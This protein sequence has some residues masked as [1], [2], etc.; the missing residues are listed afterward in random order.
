MNKQI[1]YSNLDRA[2][3]RLYLVRGCLI[4][5]IKDES[6]SEKD[7]KISDTLRHLDIAE[8]YLGQYDFRKTHLEAPN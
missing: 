4:R 2:S 1:K 7:R 6:H 3:T 8:E 5:A